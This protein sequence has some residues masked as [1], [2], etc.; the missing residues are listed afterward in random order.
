ML[1]CVYVCLCVCVCVL[2]NKESGSE[3]KFFTHT[4]SLSHTYTIHKQDLLIDEHD[5]V[6]IMK[7]KKSKGKRTLR[8]SN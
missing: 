1:L 4:H 2:N 7:K 6:A 8:G 5:K 3:K